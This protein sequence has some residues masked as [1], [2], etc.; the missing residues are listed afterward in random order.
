MLLQPPE[1]R[2]EGGAKNMFEIQQ[3]GED[4]RLVSV[5]AK[6]GVCIRSVLINLC[7][8]LTVKND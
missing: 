2:V 1:G 3:L 8:W 7:S 5:F 6:R 4:R